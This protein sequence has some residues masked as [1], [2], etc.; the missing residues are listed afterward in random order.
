MGKPFRILFTS[1]ASLRG[2]GG[3]TDPGVRTAPAEC[4]SSQ[5]WTRAPITRVPGPVVRSAGACFLIAFATLAVHL[6]RMP[7][8]AWRAP[9]P[10]ER[11]LADVPL[12]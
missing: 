8:D 9:E 12:S 11:A 5:T 1:A 4:A 10:A 2:T 6:H 7:V 3:V